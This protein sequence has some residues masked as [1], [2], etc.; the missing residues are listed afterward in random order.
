[1]NNK[2]NISREQNDLLFKAEIISSQRYRKFKNIR[3]TIYFILLFIASLFISP[4][5]ATSIH[6]SFIERVALNYILIYSILIGIAL[7]AVALYI[8][9]KNYKIIGELDIYTDKLMLIEDGIKTA[10]VIKELD[11]IEIKRGS[12]Y[13]YEYQSDNYLH[14]ANNWLIF[15]HNSIKKEIEFKIDSSQHNKYFENMI[16][17]L[18]NQKAP[19]LYSS[20]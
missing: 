2:I 1:M 20:I 16:S 12:T 13:H 11:K 9:S 3:Y 14:D 18:A 15:E 17:T 19:I 4:Q 10:Y 6:P 5:T 8:Y 7:L